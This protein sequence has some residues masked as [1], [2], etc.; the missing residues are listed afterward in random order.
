MTLLERLMAAHADA[1]MV[2][3]DFS[4]L[5]GALISESPWWDFEADCLQSLRHSRIGAVDL[6]TGGG[7]RLSALLDSLARESARP[8]RIVAT[9]GW[10]PNVPEA[11]ARLAPRHVAVLPYDSEA[12][13][14]LDLPDQSQDLVMSRHESYDPTEIARIL[15]PGGRFL[16]QQVDGFDAPEIHEWFGGEYLYPDVTL[17]A[18][19]QALRDAGMRIDDADRWEGSM[20]FLDALAL[21]TYIGL[22]PWDAPGFAVPPHAERLL[23]LNAAAPIVV[24]QRRFRIYAT[25]P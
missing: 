6:G 7:E 1:T 14:P 17:E 4:R 10:A 20:Q 16:T 13:D 22:V 5:D 11:R 12:G 8:P 15:V 9:E 25:K 2:G 19:S 23:E 24:T 18:H 3:W 21:V